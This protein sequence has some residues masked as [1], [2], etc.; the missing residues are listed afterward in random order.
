MNTFC[1]ALFAGV[2]SLTA[3]QSV[4]SADQVYMR[5]ESKPYIGR[6]TSVTPTAVT[7]E[8]QGTKAGSHEVTTNDIIRVQFDN[9]SDGMLRVEKSVLEGDFD[10]ALETLEK[11]TDDGQRREMSEEIAFD[12]ALCAAQIALA[13]RGKPHEAAVAMLKFVQAS[14]NSFHYFQACELIGDLLVADGNLKV[15]QDYYGKLAQAPWPDYKMKAQIALGRA[16]LGMNKVAEADK[17]FDD[18]LT[19]DAAGDLAEGQRLI[20]R[21]GK[22]RCQILTGKVDAAMATVKEMLS[23]S[24]EKNP[25]LQACCYNAMG[26]ALRKT[27]KPKEAIL[28]FLHTHLMYSGF[29]DADAEAVAN[30]EQLFIQ[31]HNASHAQEMRQVLDERYK[32]SRWAKMGQ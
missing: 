31:T 5:T 11:V 21:I 30:L 6:I 24:D 18:A 13:G 16:F 14:P 12:R 29:P 15:A 10:T 1:N 8:T 32:N 7:I 22:A 3:T 28:A 25:E 4:W 27:G 19:N 17:S 26:A 2:V 9:S 20:A 23:R